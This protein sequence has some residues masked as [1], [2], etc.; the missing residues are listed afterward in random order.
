[1]NDLTVIFLTVNKVPEK[2]AEYHRQVLTE[3]IRDTPIITIS[4]KPMDWG[5]NMIQEG[6]PSVPNIYRQL[7]RG[8]LVATTPYIAVVE[9]DTLYH[10]SH[11]EYRPPMDTFAFNGHRW[12]I[13]T[14]GRPFYYYK[15][16]ISNACMIAPRELAIKSL[17][18]RFEKYPENSL[19]ELG[20]E[21]GTTIDRRKSII[22]WSDV[23]IV[24]FSHVNSLD[25]TEQHKT[26]KPG[27]VQ[28][29]DIPYW[30]T[31]EEIKKRWW[32]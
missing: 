29:Y 31:A 11:F 19:G 28:A 25:P 30:G 23:G 22:Y 24:Y 21:K 15:D 27:V 3:A 14:W 12:G 26:K 4:K 13:F 20:K 6:E 5:N 9:D 17:E 10:K 32:A 1:M 7:L 18:E 2:W 8:C 16:R